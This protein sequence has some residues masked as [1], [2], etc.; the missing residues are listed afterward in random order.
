MKVFISHS[1][2]DNSIINEFIKALERLECEVFYSSKAH[3]NSIGIIR[4]Y[5]MCCKN[6]SKRSI[7]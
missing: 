6:G 4:H 7:A 3:T 5:C 1:Y 2:N